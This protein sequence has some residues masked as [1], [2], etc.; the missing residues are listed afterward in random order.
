MWKNLTDRT[1]TMTVVLFVFAY[2]DK[3]EIKLLFLIVFFC[4]FRLWTYP[5]L[6][7]FMLT[8]IMRVCLDNLHP[9]DL[10]LVR[11]NLIGQ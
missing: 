10:P 8:I 3:T 11:R 7:I 6:V 2:A 4:V 5:E 9:Q 1:C